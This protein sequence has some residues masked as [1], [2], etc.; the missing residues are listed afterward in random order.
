M[1]RSDHAAIHK[2][3]FCVCT[4]QPA[5]LRASHAMRALQ[6]LHAMST[7]SVYT[8]RHCRASSCSIELLYAY[9][10]NMA[11][12]RRRRGLKTIALEA[13]DWL[14]CAARLNSTSPQDI[15]RRAD[16]RYHNTHAGQA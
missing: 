2:L 3:W 8:C 13:Y 11:T 1:A 12:N 10:I 5:C 16:H 9:A 7:P 15:H 4:W 6:C 14:R